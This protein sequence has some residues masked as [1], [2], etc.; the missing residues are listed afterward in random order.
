MCVQRNA[1]VHAGTCTRVWKYAQKE[2]K[3]KSSCLNCD[4]GL[5]RNQKAIGDEEIHLKQKSS[6][7][8]RGVACKHAQ[9]LFEN[10]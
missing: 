4:E 7:S 6:L 5:G 9:R 10:E 1:K 8:C 3:G 2:A